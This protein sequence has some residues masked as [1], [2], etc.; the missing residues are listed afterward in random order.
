MGTTKKTGDHSVGLSSLTVFE[1][2]SS[3]F[4][5][6]ATEVHEP[7]PS[8]DADLAHAHMGDSDIFQPGNCPEGPLSSVGQTL[9]Q[10]QYAPIALT[11][12]REREKPLRLLRMPLMKH[13]PELF[14][15]VS[16]DLVIIVHRNIALFAGIIAY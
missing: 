7:F 14:E 9:L 16:H 12:A 10:H 1:Q 15:D 11:D 8:R 6:A 3:R 2:L 13:I 4:E 5:H